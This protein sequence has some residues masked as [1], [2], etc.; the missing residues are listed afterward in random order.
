MFEKISVNKDKADPL[1]RALAQEAGAYPSWNFYVYLL[2][3]DGSVVEYYTSFTSPQSTEV[4][5]AIERLL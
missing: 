5:S 4:V 2:D 1:F 3:R